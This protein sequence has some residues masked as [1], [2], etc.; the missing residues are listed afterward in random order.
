MRDRIQCMVAICV[1]LL[2][3]GALLQLIAD[4]NNVYAMPGVFFIQAALSFIVAGVFVAWRHGARVIDEMREEYL[5]RSFP[6]QP[7]LWRLDWSRRIST[8]EKSSKN[9][10]AWFATGWNL[11]VTPIAIALLHETPPTRIDFYFLSVTIVVGFALFLYAMYRI[12]YRERL[13]FP[14]LRL[15]TNPG[16]PGRTVECTL[17]VPGFGDGIRWASE[18]VC[19][20]TRTETVKVQTRYTVKK[21]VEELWKQTFTPL[22]ARSPRGA[23]LALRFLLGSEIPAM[24]AYNGGLCR[25]VV[26]IQ[27]RS[28]GGEIRFA[29]EYEVPVLGNILVSPP[30]VSARAAAAAPIAKDGLQLVDDPVDDKSGWRPAAVLSSDPKVQFCAQFTAK[31][32]SVATIL[33]ELK[34]TGIR[35]SKGG[36]IYP[37][38]LW[39][40]EP[41]ISLHANVNKICVPTFCVAVVAA[42]GTAICAPWFWAL[43]FVLLALAAGAGFGAAFYIRHHRYCVLFSKAGITRRS[44]LL[45]RSWQKTIPWNR[46]QSVVWKSLATDGRAGSMTSYRQL[47]IN[48]D[49]R[50][51]RLT[52]SPALDNHSTAEALVQLLNNITVNATTK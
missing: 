9:V 26:R 18:L 23:A 32:P 33:N 27:G 2:G 12:W 19:V 5:R 17:G 40:H 25:W 42:L 4:G 21:I 22:V 7:W 13:E 1:F 31:K 10:T 15:H 28:K 11:A 52:L 38:E 20:Y 50:T 43:P 30:V 41:L 51:T 45:S 46:I 48:P 14:P 44:R 37:D 39:R 47:V 3:V 35:F 49:D 29:H 8:V 24:G 6:N 36:M 16:R 34:A